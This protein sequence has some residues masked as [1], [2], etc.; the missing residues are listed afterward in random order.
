MD[1]LIISYINCKVFWRKHVETVWKVGD[2]F[3]HLLETVGSFRCPF[4]MHVFGAF[5]LVC[6]SFSLNTNSG[7][8]LI[9]ESLATCVYIVTVFLDPMSNFL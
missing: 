9:E 2:G 7:N 3:K 5:T 4:I 6:V 8:S 1:T